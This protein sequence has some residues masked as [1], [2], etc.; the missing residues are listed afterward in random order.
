MAMKMD[1]RF[2]ERCPRC[3]E[4]T[5]IT[6]IETSIAANYIPP[7]MEWTIRCDSCGCT[8]TE[9]YMYAYTEKTKED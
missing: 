1:I 5:N 3:G 8:F 4:G 9:T 7:C 6:T 2:G